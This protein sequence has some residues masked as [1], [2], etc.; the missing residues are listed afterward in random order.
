MNHIILCYFCIVISRL[1]PA[2][3]FV[4]LNNTQN[5]YYYYVRLGSSC[6]EAGIRSLEVLRKKN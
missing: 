1:Y 2:Y 4:Y 3:A 5:V 6:V